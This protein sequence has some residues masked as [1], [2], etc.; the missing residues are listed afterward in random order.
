MCFSA[1]A[2]FGVGVVLAAVG[3]ASLKKA[4]SPRQLPFAGIPL[5]F[6][7]QQ[8][9]EGFVWLSL[10]DPGYSGYQRI[11]PTAYLIFAQAVWPVWIPFCLL[12]ME[13][14]KKRKMI[15][16]GLA[17]LGCLVAFFLMSYIL[18]PTMSAQIREYHILYQIGIPR[19]LE[20]F[21]GLLYF[22]ST[23]FPLFISSVNRI[24]W[25]GWCAVLSYVVSSVFFQQY[26]VSVWCFFA[27]VLSVV[28]LAI[29]HRNQTAFQYSFGKFDPNQPAA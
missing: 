26:I 22:M 29:I 7:V 21:G 1:T 13:A 12:L 17:G 9:M 6:A 27:A 14:D 16:A 5:I 3:G 4:Q 11:A 28:V 23:V 18:S 25:F 2:S 8:V 10:S 24:K 15:L 19:V 20:F